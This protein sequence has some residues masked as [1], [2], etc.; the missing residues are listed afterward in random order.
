VC[1]DRLAVAQRPRRLPGGETVGG[2]YMTTVIPSARTLVVNL[3]TDDFGVVEERACGCEVGT[4]GLALHLHTIRSFEKLTGEGVAF[5]GEPLISLVEDVLP[6]RFGGSPVDYQLVEHEAGG[7]T[8][9]QVRISPR[10]GDVSEREVV[11]VAL[12]HLA[13]SSGAGLEM[14]SLWTAGETLEVVRVEPE[15]TRHGKVL[16]LALAPRGDQSPAAS[17]Q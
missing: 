4:L 16:P 12:A 15:Q 13:A 14:A 1:T 2:L 9:V 7:V 5:V 11:D 17:A 3:E 6:G 10:V 8:R